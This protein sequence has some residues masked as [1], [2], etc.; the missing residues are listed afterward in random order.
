MRNETEIIESLTALKSA[1]NIKQ[2]AISELRPFAERIASE[3][4][5]TLGP[6]DGLPYGYAIV[7]TY[8]DA[9]NE[10]CFTLMIDS[11]YRA[12]NLPLDASCLNYHFDYEPADTCAIYDFLHFVAQG[13]ID[14]IVKTVKQDTEHIH[15][16]APIMLAIAESIV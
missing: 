6:K 7:R 5:N 14:G 1:A 10:T 11:E 13:G 9:G 16:T 4:A 12:I 8:G 3:I 15:Q 2:K